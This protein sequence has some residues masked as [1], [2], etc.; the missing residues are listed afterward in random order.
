MISCSQLVGAAAAARCRAAQ[1]P[2]CQLS[3]LGPS[4]PVGAGRAQREETSVQS[5]RVKIKVRRGESEIGWRK[6]E[7]L[8]MRWSGMERGRGVN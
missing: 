1:P 2:S 8:E 5:E 3:Q 4:S 6:E 7:N